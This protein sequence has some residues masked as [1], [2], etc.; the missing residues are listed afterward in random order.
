MPFLWRLGVRESDMHL[1]QEYAGEPRP[2]NHIGRV[3]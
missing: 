1:K 2:P 3:L